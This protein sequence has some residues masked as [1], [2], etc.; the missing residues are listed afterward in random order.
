MTNWTTI[1]HEKLIAYQVA[2]ELLVVIRE[3]DISDLKLRDQAM[4]AAKSVCLNI[5]E[6]T[7]RGS[8]ADQKRVYAIARGELSEAAAA[9]DI[10][11]AAGECKVEAARNG[12]ALA[13]RAYSLLSGLLRA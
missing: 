12:H 5:A 7:G 3:A 8:P 10:A 4:R 2:R 6:A 11:L 1:P 9:L 13:V